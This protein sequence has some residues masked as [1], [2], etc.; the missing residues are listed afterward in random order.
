[1][2]MRPEDITQLIETALPGARITLRDTAGDGDH[3]EITVVA[4]QFRG[5][6]RVAQHRMV[7]DALQGRMGG[8]LHAMAV[9]TMVE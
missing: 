5:K 4:A 1:M 9:R 2:P 8:V 3:Y 6:T 7:Y